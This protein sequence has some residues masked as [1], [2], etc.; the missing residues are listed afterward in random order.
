MAEEKGVIRTISKLHLQKA[1]KIT[2]NTTKGSADISSKN[3]ISLYGKGGIELKDYDNV[4]QVLEHT[5]ANTKH[6]GYVA[7]SGATIP[8]QYYKKPESQPAGYEYTAYTQESVDTFK[9]QAER[10]KHL[11]GYNTFQVFSGKEFIHALETT[12]ASD[13][14]INCMAI[15]THGGP[16]ALY[17]KCD[18]GFYD[19]SVNKT[20]KSEDANIDGLMQSINNGK[21]KFSPDAICFIDACGVGYGKSLGYNLCLKTGLIVIA[22]AG[23]HTEMVTPSVANG[24]FKVTPQEKDTGFYK[25]RRETQYVD[26]NAENPKYSW[27]NPFNDEPK[28]ISHKEIEYDAKGIFIA[29]SVIIDL[30]IMK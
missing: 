6:P 28:Y 3:E 9:Q 30:L 15:F 29:D 26:V 12:T 2:W 8:A 27:W 14:Y 10:L 16:N 21:I 19:G 24:Q 1:E 4:E 25:Y 20:N 13:G 22:A 17:F 23:I 18:E 11:Y 7:I 5:N